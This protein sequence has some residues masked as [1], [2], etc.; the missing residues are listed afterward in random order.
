[1]KDL[2]LTVAFPP[3]QVAWPLARVLSEAGLKQL[4]IAETEKYAHVTFFFNGGQEVQYAGEDR[5]LVPSPRVPS[6]DEVPAM[7]AAEITKKLV[8]TIEENKYDFIVVNFANADM[9]AH[10]GNLSATVVAAEV[11]DN[12]LGEISGAVLDQK[13]LLIIT[14]DHG[15]AE[16]LFNPQTGKIDKEHST[17]V[18]PCYFIAEQ[19]AGKSVP[20]YNPDLSQMTASGVLADVAPTILQIMGLKRP[21]EMTGRPLI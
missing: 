5:I 16:E 7:S 13:G 3:E 14:A 4:H 15:N 1:E 20:G 17:N 21:E 10:T 11:L 18:V 2:P 12:L 9:V 6:Y 8:A 19:F